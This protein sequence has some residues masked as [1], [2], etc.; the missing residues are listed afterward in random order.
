PYRLRAPRVPRARQGVRLGAPRARAGRDPAADPRRL[1]SGSWNARTPGGFLASW[2]LAFSPVNGMAGS[3]LATEV[4]NGW[5]SDSQAERG[6]GVPPWGSRRC[7]AGT[8][9]RGGR[10]TG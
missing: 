4:S 6:G 9:G 7:R 3:Y 10:A 8:A 5:R 1:D 2:V